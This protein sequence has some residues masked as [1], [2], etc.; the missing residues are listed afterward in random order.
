MRGGGGGGGG[1]WGTR[2]Q[3]VGWKILAALHKKIMNTPNKSGESFHW[4]KCYR[5]F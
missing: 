3:F 2:V 5:Y 1:G 4:F